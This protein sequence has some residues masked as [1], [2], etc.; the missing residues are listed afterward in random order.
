MENK[1][2]ERSKSQV[3]K[4]K[5]H[6]VVRIRPTEVG[7]EFTS[8]I[9]NRDDL[10]K[11]VAKVSDTE[12]KVS[13][14]LIEDKIFEFDKV[15]KHTINQVEV[16]N[17]VAKNII[18]DV[19][20]GYNGTIMAY[21]QTGS[22]KT[23]T[24]FGK[25]ESLDYNAEE[26]LNSE[27]GIVPRAIC[28]L[29]DQLR[30]EGK[31]VKFKISVS[32]FQV[33][34]EQITDLIPEMEEEDGEEINKKKTVP[35]NFNK[36]QSNNNSSLI[37]QAKKDAGEGLRI[38]EDPKTGVFIQGLKQ[39]QVEDEEQL[40]GLIK[41]A[42]KNRITHN[43]NMNHTSSRSHAI[44]RILFEKRTYNDAKSTKTNY[45]TTKGLLT[46]VDLAGSEKSKLTND[47]IRKEE[48]KYINSSIY[49]LGTVV[50]NLA[51]QNH[52]N[53]R[54]TSLTRI[55][56]DCL[57]GN[58]KNAI[59]ATVSPF[60]VNYEETI[61]TLQFASQAKLIKVNA[62][63]NVQHEIKT[64]K[65]QLY[66]IVNNSQKSN[67]VSNKL[68]FITNNSNKGQKKSINKKGASYSNSP[69][70]RIT[71]LLMSKHNS[72]L[73]LNQNNAYSNDMIVEEDFKTI[74]KKYFQVISHLQNELC[75]K[76][77][78]I[79][80]L[81]KENRELKSKLDKNIKPT[82]SENLLSKNKK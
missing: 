62:T 57:C 76:E 48:S 65:D 46:F 69:K 70:E 81:L 24:I 15:L 18:N 27:A 37:K 77:I 11:I 31:K 80:S 43:T 53:F 58:S 16:F 14:P 74:N 30:N 45:S 42:T 25:Q 52:V 47:G 63:A 59:C 12:L 50:Y 9:F 44:L 32:F 78:E 3:K 2:L 60:L 64:M 19:T 34:L 66:N 4:T 35:M 13:R 72:G 40:L 61:T 82:N 29:F 51:N 20:E 33:Y 49:H 22:G 26:G 23:Y 73:G 67:L 36:N 6:I 5:F 68:S 71:N 17:Y 55:L 56:K 10:R 28:Y 8:G 79:Y 39:I 7:E 21:G 75:Q 54:E 38:R 41:Y 1:G